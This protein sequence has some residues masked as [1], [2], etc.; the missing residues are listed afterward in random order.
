MGSGGAHA[1]LPPG[2]TGNLNL[3]EYKQNIKQ[4]KK[5]TLDYIV[6]PLGQLVRVS[7][8]PL[9]RLHTPPIYVVVFNGPLGDLKSQ[10]KLILRE[11]SHLYAFSGYP[12][13]T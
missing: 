5:A 10:G 2:K 7:S 11:A 1:L 9:Q 12:V 8:T 4:T 6:K 13:R 3:K